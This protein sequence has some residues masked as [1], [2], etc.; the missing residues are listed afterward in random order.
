[1]RVG[2]W[3]GLGLA[4]ASLAMAPVALADEAAVAEHVQ[5]AVTRVQQGP[6]PEVGGE[7]IS[8]TILLP[9]FYE[10]RQFRPAWTPAALDSLLAAVRDSA[11]DGDAARVGLGA[12]V[13]GACSTGASDA[14]ASSDAPATGS[15]TFR[16]SSPAAS[17]SASRSR[18]PSSSRPSSSS[19][20][21]RPA[22]STRRQVAGFCAP[23]ASSTRRRVTRSSW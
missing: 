1:M 3:W 19:R 13:G 5:Q 7:P 2:R 6:R 15:T 16:R 18:A 23:F 4:V 9:V 21:S 12:F 14:A 20:T 10:D 22:T 17:S 11:L 8:S